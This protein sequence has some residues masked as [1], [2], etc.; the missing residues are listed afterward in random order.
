MENLV[1][2]VFTE[3]KASAYESQSG[4]DDV[5]GIEDVVEVLTKSPDID[6]TNLD[7]SARNPSK[8]FNNFWETNRM[9]VK[10]A[11]EVRNVLKRIKE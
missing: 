3:R 2:K 8:R 5:I 9:K 7:D 6:T 11:L 4:E 1:E 10:T